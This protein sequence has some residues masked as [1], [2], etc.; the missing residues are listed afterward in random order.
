MLLLLLLLL[1]V[2]AVVAEFLK[3]LSIDDNSFP[4]RLQ[5]ARLYTSRFTLS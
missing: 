4:R 1:L 5:S 2:L 3:S